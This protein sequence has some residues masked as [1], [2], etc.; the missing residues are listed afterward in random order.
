MSGTWVL[1]IHATAVLREATLLL[2]D[3]R[4][5][6]DP[7]LLTADQQYA[8]AAEVYKQ[9]GSH[10]L[11]ATPDFAQPSTP[12]KTTSPPEQPTK[13]TRS[14]HSPS[15]PERRS[16]SGRP[17]GIRGPRVEITNRARDP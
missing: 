16:T 1:L 3:A 17:S 9:L 15:G 2:A 5:W 6:R 14:S 12:Q 11:A 13:R 8:E 7:L 10:P 4:R